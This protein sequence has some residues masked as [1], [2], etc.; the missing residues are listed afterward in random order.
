MHELNECVSSRVLKLEKENRELQASIERL[1]EDNHL[2]QE[3]QLH[4]QELDRENQS[5]SKKV[6]GL[7]VS[8]HFTHL[9]DPP[10]RKTSYVVPI[11]CSS[12]CILMPPHVPSY[13][14]YISNY[15]F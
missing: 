15:P 14:Y 11:H 5:L 10:Q 8:L 4:T 13:F 12:W 6:G 1:K 7:I 3:Q 9:I 2:L